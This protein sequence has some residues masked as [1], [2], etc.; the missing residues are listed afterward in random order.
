MKTNLR[1]LLHGFLILVKNVGFDVLNAV[2]KKGSVFRGITSC[3][4][5]KFNKRFG[6]T[7]CL[8]L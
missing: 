7:R 3:S 6:G 5:L 4:T 8:L 1:K 2:D